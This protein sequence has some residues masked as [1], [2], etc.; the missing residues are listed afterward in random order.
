[1]SDC[2]SAK[3]KQAWWTKGGLKMNKGNEKVRKGAR[4]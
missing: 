2:Q 4:S 3:E 1:M